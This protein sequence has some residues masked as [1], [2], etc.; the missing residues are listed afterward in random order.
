MTTK[1]ASATSGCRATSSGTGREG[2]VH[3]FVGAG[4][5]IYFIQEKDNGN[6]FGED[7][8]KLGGTVFGGV[9]FFTSNTVSVKG[10]AR[11]HLIDNINGLNPDGLALT[12]GLKKYF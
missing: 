6:S 11:Y 2:A 8:T 7:H 10:E 3:P 1:T 4:L 5:G 12:I 9:E